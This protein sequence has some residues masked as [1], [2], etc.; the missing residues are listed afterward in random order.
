MTLRHAPVRVIVV[1][2]VG[3]WHH[4]CSSAH[5]TEDACARDRLGCTALCRSKVHNN[6]GIHHFGRYVWH[7]HHIVHIHAD[8]SGFQPNTFSEW[9]ALQT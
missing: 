7:N 3:D 4:A 2:L 1:R 8:D 5:Q 9:L 6:P